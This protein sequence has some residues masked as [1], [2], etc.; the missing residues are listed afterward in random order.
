[1][2]SVR[3]LTLYVL[4][5]GECEHNVDGRLASQDDSP[6]TAKGREQARAN[7]KLLKEIAGDLGAFDFFASSLHRT[8]V[9]MELTREAAGLPPTGYRADHRL[10][11]MHCGDQIWL[12]W[13]D[14]PPEDRARYRADPWNLARPGGESQ[15]RVYDRVGKFL[16]TLTRPSIIVAHQAPVRMIRAHY[17][18]LT[19]NEAVRYEQPH[20]GILRLGAGGEAHFGE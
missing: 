14:I 3:E 4:R 7:G 16:A 6:L 12:R 18:G 13:S 5:H 20:D 2:P 1:M 10:M 11:E 9:T 8:C 19:P 15:A 17:L